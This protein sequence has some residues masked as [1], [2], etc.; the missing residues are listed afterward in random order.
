MNNTLLELI[1]RQEE[2]NVVTSHADQAREKVQ[3]LVRQEEVWFN[4]RRQEELVRMR[5]T[6]LRSE[7][8]NK[9]RD[10]AEGEQQYTEFCIH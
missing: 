1:Q 4:R 3:S 6:V 7:L 2:L 9:E 5:L 10:E 8:V